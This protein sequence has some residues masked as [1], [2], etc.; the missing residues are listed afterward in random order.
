MVTDDR[1][2]LSFYSQDMTVAEITE[3]LGLNP[4]IS[5]DVGD[6]KGRHSDLVHDNTHWGYRVEHQ[7]ANMPGTGSL[8][9][10]LRIFADKTEQIDSLRRSCEIRLWWAGFSDNS[11]GGFVIDPD[12]LQ[13][14]AAIRCAL[15]GTVYMTD[16]SDD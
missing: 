4:T 14:V 12:T 1:A 16:H 9:E 10:L 13:A 3:V 5:H 8:R 11:Q 15:F 7:D 6:R 2:T